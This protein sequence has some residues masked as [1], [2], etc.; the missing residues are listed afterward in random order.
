MLHSDISIIGA[1]NMGSAL[2]RALVNAKVVP[3]AQITVSDPSKEKLS[4]L[5]KFG[6]QT[7]QDNLKTL[8]SDFLILAVKPQQ[9]ADLAKELRGKIPAK[10]VVI[11]IMAGVPIAKIQA[12]L[13]HKKI[14]RAMPNT[15]AL[16]GKGVIGWFAAPVMTATEKT[17]AKK[18]LQAGGETFEFQDETLLNDVT[19]LSGC[20]PGF[21]F[22]LIKA[23]ENAISTV[24]HVPREQS[25]VMLRKTIEGSLALLA[26]TGKTPETLMNEVASRGGATEA[27]LRELEKGGLETLFT[28]M[29][30]KAYDRC[31]ELAEK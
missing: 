12:E 3:T 15:P 11:S 5:A 2:V 30:K 7:T 26:S 13:Q 21:L 9:F 18:I 1:G 19:A 31:R 6:V 28:N 20:G 4:R 10:T 23:W 17:T 29:V 27:G 8:D 22:A 25:T 14:V 24:L 16:I